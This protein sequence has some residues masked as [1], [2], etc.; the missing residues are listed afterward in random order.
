MAAEGGHS[1]PST[2][3]PFHRAQKGFDAAP[4]KLLGHRFFVAN[5]CIRR[6]PKLFLRRV[7]TYLPCSSDIL[8]CPY[9][10]QM[11]GAFQQEN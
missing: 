4:L 10:S 11:H 1:D 9:E 2:G 7:E 6:L 8:V 5:V 3:G